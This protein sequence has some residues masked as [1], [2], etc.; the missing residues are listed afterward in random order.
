MIRPRCESPP[1]AQRETQSRHAGL[2]HDLARAGYLIRRRAW[3][4]LKTEFSGHPF[5]P[6]A[7]LS[8]A[9][10]DASLAMPADL[11]WPARILVEA[12]GDSYESVAHILIALGGGNV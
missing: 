12:D 9:I 7:A 3:R 11:L 10:A 1:L 6:L 2:A 4:H 8:G 5:G